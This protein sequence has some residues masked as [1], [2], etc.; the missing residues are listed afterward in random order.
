MTRD[1]IAGGVA[2]YAEVVRAPVA[3]PRDDQPG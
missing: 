2:R 3:L 1:E